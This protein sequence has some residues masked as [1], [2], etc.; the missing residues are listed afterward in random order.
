MIRRFFCRLLRHDHSL[1]FIL[2]RTVEGR[3]LRSHPMDRWTAD[4]ILANNVAPGATFAGQRVESCRI[5]V[6]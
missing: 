1:V 3:V 6:P 5:V 2:C 4:H